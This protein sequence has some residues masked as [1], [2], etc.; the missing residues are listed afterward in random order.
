MMDMDVKVEKGREIDDAGNGGVKGQH[1]RINTI[2]SNRRAHYH[3]PGVY[4]LNPE[5][6]KD[7]FDMDVDTDTDTETDMTTTV[8][9]RSRSKRPWP[10]TSASATSATLTHSPLSRERHNEDT[11]GHFTVQ[12]LRHSKSWT[13]L[14][15]INQLAMTQGNSSE[16]ESE[17]KRDQETSRRRRQDSKNKSE[18]NNYRNNNTFSDKTPEQK[19]ERAK[20]D[21][22]DRKM[23]A[24]QSIL[25]WQQNKTN[26]NT[27]LNNP[28][29]TQSSISS[30]STSTSTAIFPHKTMTTTIVAIDDISTGRPTYTATT[31]TF[32][33]SSA[34]DDISTNRS[35]T[36]I[37][38][39]TTTTTTTTGSARPFPPFAIRPISTITADDISCYR[40]SRPSPA[41]IRVTTAIASTEDISC[42]PIRHTAT[43]RT[44]DISSRPV[45]PTGRTDDILSKPTRPS[46]GLARTDDISTRTDVIASTPIRPFPPF[47]TTSVNSPVRT[48]S[49]TEDIS[50]RPTRPFPPFATT[51]R[52]TTTTMTAS[53]ATDDISC[54]RPTAR[55][56]PMR[57]QFLAFT[58]II[59]DIATDTTTTTT[60][61][62]SV[63]YESSTTPP[64]PSTNSPHLSIPSPASSAGRFSPYYYSQ[65]SP[66]SR[67]AGAA[68]PLPARRCSA[69]TS[70]QMCILQGFLDRHSNGHIMYPKPKPS[71]CCS[72][73]GSS[74]SG[75][76]SE[77]DGEEEGYSSSSNGSSSSPTSFSDAD[78]DSEDEDKEE[79]D[80]DEEDEEFQNRMLLLSQSPN[81]SSVDFRDFFMTERQAT[82]NTRQAD[83]PVFFQGFPLLNMTRIE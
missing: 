67:A 45:R 27:S 13:C 54:Y 77:E 24:V 43:A 73:S 35:T 6:T 46:A 16:D 3:L 64:P 75:S 29:Y 2:N 80:I 26:Q 4:P 53:T 19:E 69:D 79:E 17:G 10:W 42:S 9:K 34:V 59:D 55:P 32:S 51:T 28:N 63:S 65:L 74:C 70:I 71:K 61:T 20:L 39:T 49:K 11:D 47:A 57:P 41:S 78:S 33:S 40:P 5:R 52:T 81:L 22:S 21:E 76:G 7:L 44:D 50:S 68:S 60:S 18:I 48:A 56:V 8:G 83:S 23:L 72:L 36:T 58:P 66:Y 38:T 62:L 82:A 15:D 25:Q 37:T 12:Y 1:S 31:A 30:N 14:S